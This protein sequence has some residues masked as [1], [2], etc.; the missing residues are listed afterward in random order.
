MWFHIL[1]GNI[2]IL[3]FSSVNTLDHNTTK[4]ICRINFEINETIA[5]PIL[6]YYQ[7]ENFHLNHRSLVRSKIFTQL[8]GKTHVDSSNNS[9]CDGAKFVYEIFN[10]DSSK[11]ITPWGKPLKG[12]DYANPCGLA[13]KSF[14]NGKS[15]FILD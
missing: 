15:F 11:Y 2:K 1:I 8:R 12:E 5:A 4:S 13:A 14:F 9:R 7:I 10:N 6:F 3:N